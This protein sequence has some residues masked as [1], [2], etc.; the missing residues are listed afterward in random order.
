MEECILC[1]VEWLVRLLGFDPTFGAM[2]HIDISGQ[3]D[4]LAWAYYTATFDAYSPELATIVATNPAI[5]FESLALLESWTPVAQG[6]GDSGSTALIT[7]DMVDDGN[8]LADDIEAQASAGL[9]TFLAHEQTAV[10]GDALVGMNAEAAWAE[11]ESQR[12]FSALF[13][14]IVLNESD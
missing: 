13:L 2:H 3:E 7:Q 12:N 5:L 1:Y 6:M 10:D 4:T 14:T 9:Q 8:S 11:V